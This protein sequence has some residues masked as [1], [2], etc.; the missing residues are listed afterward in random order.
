MQAYHKFLPFLLTVRRGKNS[1]KDFMRENSAGHVQTESFYSNYGRAFRISGQGQLLHPFL[2]LVLLRRNSQQ[3]VLFRHWRNTCAFT[4]PEPCKRTVLLR[5]WGDSLD[6]APDSAPGEEHS[7]K[8][9][10]LPILMTEW[11]RHKRSVI[12]LL[13]FCCQY[14]RDWLN[15][16]A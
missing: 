11:L 15:A 10:L 2:K 6:L 14:H 7:G 5:P 8:T 13:F 12:R 4:P 9:R 3:H 16:P 1:R